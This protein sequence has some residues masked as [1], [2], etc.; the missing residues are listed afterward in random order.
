[1]HDRFAPTLA[2]LLLL[3]SCSLQQVYGTGQQWQ[4]NECQKINDRD[5]RARCEKSTATSYEDYKSQ[6]EKASKP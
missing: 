6:A 2:A 4:R 5:E 3:G 1:M